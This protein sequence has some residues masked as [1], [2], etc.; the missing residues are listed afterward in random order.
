MK[1]LR[2]E[3]VN[4]VAPALKSRLDWRQGS[5]LAMPDRGAGVVYLD[6]FRRLQPEVYQHLQA[7]PKWF[8]SAPVAREEGGFRLLIEPNYFWEKG[9]LRM[10]EPKDDAEV[11]LVTHRGGP[12]FYSVVHTGGVLGAL[13][14]SKEQV[15]ES[16]I[17]AF[18]PKAE[19]LERNDRFS[20]PLSKVGPWVD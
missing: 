3:L 7:D 11:T 12:L 1:S 2:R 4:Q 19:V 20:N 15:I 13:W 18:F 14:V 8:V 9:S 17:P 10:P 6:F 5:V 16:V